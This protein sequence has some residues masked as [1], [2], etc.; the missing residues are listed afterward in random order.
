MFLS[1]LNKMHPNLKFACEIGP[2]KLVFKDNQIS[3]SSNNDL[4]LI[5]SV[6]RKPT[7]TKTILNFQAVCPW[8]WKCG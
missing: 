8:I 4:R 7:D 3:L 1:S 6:H 2:H 5:T